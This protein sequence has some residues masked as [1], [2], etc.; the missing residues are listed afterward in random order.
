MKIFRD[1][2]LAGYP[3]LWVETHEE[4][5]AMAALCKDLDASKGISNDFSVAATAMNQWGKLQGTAMDRLES[6]SKKLANADDKQ[7]E[8]YEMFISSFEDVKKELMPAIRDFSDDVK[9]FRDSIDEMGQKLPGKIANDLK[10]LAQAIWNIRK[11]LK[12]SA[13]STILLQEETVTV[14][15]E[16]HEEL[17]RVLRQGSRDE[18]YSR[19]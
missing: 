15:K 11:D 18:L 4:Y 14:F 10:N 1:Y 3:L 12:S 5:R 9:N 16:L 8:A 7:L 17:L 13:D 2:V 6:L 19:K